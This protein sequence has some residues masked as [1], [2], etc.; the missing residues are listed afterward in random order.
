M[1]TCI[2]MYSA[3]TGGAQ[4]AAAVIDV[5]SPGHLVG[6]QW[7]LRATLGADFVLSAQLSFR[8]TPSFSTNDDRGIISEILGSLDLTTSG[9]GW[10]NNPGYNLLPDI[11]VMGG[12]RLYLH[13][14]T[15][16]SVTGA[17]VALVHFDFDLDKVSMRRR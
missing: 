9:V 1:G 5:P 2:K 4:D 3:I 10:V 12:E 11:P 16:A 14:S 17:V 13:I 7:G 6:V 15:T 8:S